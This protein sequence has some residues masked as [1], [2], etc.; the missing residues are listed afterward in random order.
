MRLP[1]KIR[2]WLV[3]RHA[4]LQFHARSGWSH[5]EALVV[6]RAGCLQKLL[7]NQK[8]ICNGKDCWQ[9]RNMWHSADCASLEK[10]DT[11]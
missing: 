11:K 10:K 1:R 4:D 2:H 9:G 8:P 6:M 5:S 7:D 3:L